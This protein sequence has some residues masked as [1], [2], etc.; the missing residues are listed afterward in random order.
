S[1]MTRRVREGGKQHAL[2]EG[3]LSLSSGR[4]RLECLD[5][6]AALTE[7]KVEATKTSVET[8]SR[9]NMAAAGSASTPTLTQRDLAR[10]TPDK[11]ADELNGVGLKAM[12]VSAAAGSRAVRVVVPGGSAT[13]H[14]D[15]E[16][17]ID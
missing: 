11:L 16:W 9:H 4:I 13:I 5:D 12:V 1:E 15:N 7:P 10:W 17:N 14:L 6:D 3:K 8:S 2:V